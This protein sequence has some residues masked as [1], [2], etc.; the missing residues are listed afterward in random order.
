MANEL[1]PTTFEELKKLGNGEVVEL[2]GFIAEEPFRARL[3]K[4]SILG[5]AQSGKIPNT[6]MA[7]AIS[8]FDKDGNTKGGVDPQEKMAEMLDLCRILAEN[9]LIEPTLEEI[10][11]AGLELTDQQL[12]AIFNYTQTGVSQVESFHKKQRGT[13]GDT[14]SKTA[15]PAAQRNTR[16]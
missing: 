7:S 6:L 2:P 16:S 11:T 9:A 13:Q 10:K 3:R 4:P 12:I 1:K 15:K 5:L 8:L 14:A